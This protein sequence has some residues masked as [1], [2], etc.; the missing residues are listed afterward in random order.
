MENK[1]VKHIEV[2]GVTYDVP[3]IEGFDLV[4]KFGTT[5]EVQDIVNGGILSDLEY[6]AMVMQECKDKTDWNGKMKSVV[7][8]DIPIGK[9]TNFKQAFEYNNKL[10]Y[11]PALQLDNATILESMFQYGAIP[12][13]DTISMPNATN[14]KRVFYG[15][16]INKVQDEVVVDFG[17]LK[18][19]NSFCDGSSFFQWSPT[20]YKR[21]IV[22]GD[23][24]NN[25]SS[26]IANGNGSIDEFIAL[27]TEN[28]TTL[29]GIFSNID[30]K[31]ATFGS[32]EKVTN[33]TN[34]TNTAKT[35]NKFTMLKMRNWKTTNIIISN[36]PNILLIY[37]KY[38]IFHAMSIEDGATSRTLV[39]HATPLATWNNEGTNTIPTADDAEF[40][41]VEDWDRYKK[42]DGTLY[43]WGEIA[44]L[45]KD[46]TVA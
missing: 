10:Q 6:T 1:I 2:N 29:N 28:V 4:G 42:D 39:L 24:C 30:V 40:L 34:F 46:I 26:F 45:I 44:S 5:K 31:E 19:N 37:I 9:V 32:V 3:T 18:D 15:T 25:L 23:R 7:Y 27:N 43:T 11:L 41:E 21:V 35:Y 16:K 17:W 13:L 36:V 33:F 14:A 20:S 12:I 38:I 22:T 8:V